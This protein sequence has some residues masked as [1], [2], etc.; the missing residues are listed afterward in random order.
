[1]HS[2][3]PPYTEMSGQL[4]T[5]PA[6][7]PGKDSPIPLGIKRGGAQNRSKHGEGKVILY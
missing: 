3:P 5:Q 4:H 1:M 6:V 2:K 7:S